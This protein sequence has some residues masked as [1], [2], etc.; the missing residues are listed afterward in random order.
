MQA[1][2]PKVLDDGKEAT[3]LST[4]Q[5]K[6]ICIR[7][8]WTCQMSKVPTNEINVDRRIVCDRRYRRFNAVMVAKS[9]GGTIWLCLGWKWD[10]EVMDEQQI[11]KLLK[12]LEQA[13]NNEL[14]GLCSTTGGQA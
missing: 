7:H 3:C 13:H 8:G 11:V 9:A 5:I 2:K 4:R 12:T 1:T 10:I 14:S 6:N